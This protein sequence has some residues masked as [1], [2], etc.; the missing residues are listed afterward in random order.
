MLIPE[1]GRI[2]L[3]C[4]ITDMRKSINTL[5][6][7]VKDVLAMEPTSGHLFLFRGR[8]G[9]KLKAL[10]YEE[11]SFTLWYRRL[12]KGKFVFPRN[13]QGTIELS[14]AHFNWLLASNKYAPRPSLAC[15]HS[16]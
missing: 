3:Y 10:Y 5:A 6:M 7:M 16:T 1:S 9:D 8:G 12:E 14:Q 11:N 13:A 4:G 15:S 2:H